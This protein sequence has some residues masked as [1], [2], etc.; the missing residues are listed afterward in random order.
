MGAGDAPPKTP[1]EYAPEVEGLDMKAMGAD[2]LYKGFLKGAHARGFSNADLSWVLG[3]YQQRLALSNS[4][5][6]GEA[7]LRKVWTDDA[8]MQKGL[9]NCYRG[10]AAFAGGQEQL[11]RLMTKFGNDPDF[12]QFAA[13]VGAELGEDSAVVGITA[14]ESETLEALMA[15]E[16]YTNPSHAEHAKVVARTRALYEKKYPNQPG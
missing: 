6:A 15:S 16:A 13:R 14:A 10:G 11:D 8:A 7:E 4:P 9:A 12:V 1:D 3:E 5:E 2:P